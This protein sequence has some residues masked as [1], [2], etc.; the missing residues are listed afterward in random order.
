M[1]GTQFEISL[2]PATGVVVNFTLPEGAGKEVARAA[3]QEACD[4]MRVGVVEWEAWSEENSTPLELKMKK[5]QHEQREAA[6]E[7]WEEMKQ[8]RSRAR[9]M[10]ADEAK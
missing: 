5:M 9:Q 6:L 8:G 4:L 7:Q 10:I 2:G 1:S 3:V